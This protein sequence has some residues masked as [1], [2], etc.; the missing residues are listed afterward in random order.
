MSYQ[1]C[2]LIVKCCEAVN[3]DSFVLRAVSQWDGYETQHSEQ[4]GAPP[5]FLPSVHV[6]L[7][8]TI[9]LVGGLGVE[10]Q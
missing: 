8:T 2:R 1:Y 5:H 10:D 6:C 7:L 3:G 9:L 4:G